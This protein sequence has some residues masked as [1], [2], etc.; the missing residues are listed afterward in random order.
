MFKKVMAALLATVA[1]M[2]AAQAQEGGPRGDR[3]AGMPQRGDNGRRA[4][5]QRAPEGQRPEMQRRDRQFDRPRAAP[6]VQAQAQPQPQPQPQPRDNGY[7]SG[8]GRGNM[9][10]ERAQRRQAEAQ[11]Q[12]QF[13]RQR[14][15]DRDRGDWQRDN[16][17]RDTPVVVDRGRTDADRANGAPRFDGQRFDGQRPDDRRRL[18]DERRNGV[19]RWTSN[20]AGDRNRDDRARDGRNWGN[21]R[22]P[23]NNWSVGNW[24]NNDRNGRNDWN[25]QW[26]GDNRY[27]WGRYRQQNRNLF[28]LPR[29]YAPSQW[30]YG[31]RRF[32]IGVTL[33]SLLWGQDYWIGDPAYYRLP[34][35]YG[36]YRWVR[37]Y[38]DALLVDLRSGYVVDTVYDIF[39]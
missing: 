24:S 31:Y 25:R 33:S 10:A 8:E 32:S 14:D 39:W 12:P 38:N 22:R 20:R 6:P 37:Y 13:A 27:D 3:G 36:P 34:P 7:Y 29:Y 26:R 35:A 11:G 28:R 9:V 21:D 4:D 15:G 17:R 2:P 5:V 16:G 23:S 18:D 19:Q 1:F 30:N